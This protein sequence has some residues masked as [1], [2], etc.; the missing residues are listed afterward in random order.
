MKF[1]VQTTIAMPEFLPDEVFGRNNW[2]GSKVSH[3]H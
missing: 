3:L 2:I 1:S